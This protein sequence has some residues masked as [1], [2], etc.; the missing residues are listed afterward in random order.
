M[1]PCAANGL[2]NDVHACRHSR[3]MYCTRFPSLD[4]AIMT[5]S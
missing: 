3:W 2:P 5:V 1:P 4:V